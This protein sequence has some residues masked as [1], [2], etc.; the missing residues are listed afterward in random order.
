MLAALRVPTDR[1]PSAHAMPFARSPSE[2]EQTATAQAASLDA[3]LQASPIGVAVT[4]E[5]QIREVNDQLCAMTGYSRADLIGQTTRILHISDEHYQAVGAALYP[6]LQLQRVARMD[7]EMRCKDGQILDVVLCLALID[8]D[9]P[10]LGVVST[11]IDVS[12]SRRA[13]RLLRTRLALS[14]FT[15]M[16]DGRSIV[17]RV[18]TDTLQLTRGAVARLRLYE[19]GRKERLDALLV[20]YPE[21]LQFSME[22]VEDRDGERLPGLS[23]IRAGRHAAEHLVGLFAGRRLEVELPASSGGCLLARLEVGGK[24]AKYLDTER[25]CARQLASMA[26]DALEAVR[27]AEALRRSE[28]W[29]QLAIE[30]AGDGVWDYDPRSGMVTV[31]AAYLSMLGRGAEGLRLHI[32]DWQ[33]MLHPDDRERLLQQVSSLMESE[34]QIEIEY[35]LRRADGDWC[36]VL[37]RARVI[38][39]DEAGQALR[40]MGIHVDITERKHVDQQRERLQELLARTEQISR[41]GSWEWELESGHVLWSPELFRLFQLEPAQGPIRFADKGWVFDAADRERLAQAL[42]QAVADGQPLDLELNAVRQD[43]S[44]WLCRVCGY[45]QRDLNGRIVSVYGSMQDITDRRAAEHQLRLAASVFA[46]SLEGILIMDAQ[47]RILDVNPGFSRITGFGKDAIRGSDP[48]LLSSDQYPRLFDTALWAAL[49]HSGAWQG[50][51][52]L[53]RQDGTPAP[54]ILSVSRVLDHAGAVQ[55]YVAVFSDITQVKAHE[56]ELERIAYHDPLTGLPNRRLLTDRLTQAVALAD[57]SG[58]ALAVCYLDLDGFK[59]INDRYGHDV[60]DQLL[61]KVAE[62]LQQAL[63]VQDSVARFGGDEFVLMFPELHDPEACEVLLERVL[64]SVRQPIRIGDASHQVFASIGFTLYPMDRSDPDT[65]LRHADQAMYHAKETG[66]NRYCRYDKVAVQEY[67]V[68]GPDQD[69]LE[70]AL[71][72][73]ELV[74]YYQPQVDL[75]S[76]EVIGAE[77]LIRWQHPSKGLL[78]PGLFLPAVEGRAL[79]RAL[80]DW[81]IGSALEQLALWN[82]QGLKLALGINISAGHLTEPGFAKRLNEQLARHPSVTPEDVELEIVETTALS[83][84]KRADRIL[85]ECQALGV[86]FA[87]DDFGTDYSSLAY[88]RA[89]AVDVLKI[90]Q[91]FVRDM[92]DDPGDMEIVESVV[93]LS[94][95]FSRL[96]IAEGIETLEHAVL[97]TWLGC[98]HGQGYGIARPMPAAELPDWCLRWP[99]WKEWPDADQ[100]GD[101]ADIELMMAALNHRQWVNQVMRVLE[102]RVVP[103]AVVAMSAADCP[104]GHWHQVHETAWYAALPEF[105]EIGPL[106]EHV[107]ALAEALLLYARSGQRQIARNRLADL[108][109]ARREL[110]AKMA[111]LM[112][113]MQRRD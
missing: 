83:D 49:E 35:R 39:R 73:N 54:A 112:R 106:H 103:D 63:R 99:S 93:R 24:R 20:Q 44:R 97:L 21:G 90:D 46:H 69:A 81:V 28:D 84:F 47:R 104:F 111:Q 50:E 30:A 56:A 2:P 96:V 18:L 78:A 10:A 1:V 38:E 37:S 13:E 22:A 109:A 61:I 76:R 62:A 4:V 70:Q 27:T 107:H 40:M 101:C 110:T 64:T 14:G 23:S 85:S 57:R 8:P 19:P 15:A 17:E 88:F 108:H 32:A 105:Q 33:A 41:V 77:A 98:R 66:R 60:G 3:L 67:A 102:G 87:L 65:L 95:A 100:S 6:Q 86:R 72:R 58:R 75:I 91:S 113:L 68:A 36:W 82:Q 7:T 31:N 94:Q 71:E 25:S 42:D 80:G 5:R 74:L 92:L 59:P 29:A 51:V 26:A 34:D 52:W 9:R 79:E 53:R 89:L 55:N 16:R 12:Q 45:P 48:A 11:V 43:G